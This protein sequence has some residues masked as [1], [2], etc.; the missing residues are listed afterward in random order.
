MGS[1]RSSPSSRCSSCPTTS[2]TCASATLTSRATWPS[3]S[4]SSRARSRPE[5]RRPD[6][7][8]CHDTFTRDRPVPEASA[9]YIRV[10]C[11]CYPYERTA[12]DSVRERVHVRVVSASV[13]FRCFFVSMFLCSSES[14]GVG[15][16]RLLTSYLLTYLLPRE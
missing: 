14:P 13:P 2:P 12:S 10:L 7:C 1:C 5:A 16:L 4:P 3:R 6:R 9:H 15:A 8:C 11:V